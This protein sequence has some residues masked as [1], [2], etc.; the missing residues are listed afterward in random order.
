VR[1]AII[2]AAAT[3]ASM[4]A[5]T[6]TANAATV[7]HVATGEPCPAV[8]A[9]GNTISGGCLV[10]DLDGAWAMQNP[11]SPPIT[12]TSCTLNLDIRVD[13]TGTVLYG[14]N[15]T[16]NCGV[17]D[18]VACTDNTTS[19]KLPWPTTVGWSGTD[20]VYQMD[21][22]LENPTNPSY[23]TWEQVPLTPKEGPF[24]TFLGFEQNGN[25]QNGFV[26]GL[27][28]DQLDEASRVATEW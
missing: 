24:D 15:Q 26:A 3:I 2:L 5:M 16:N 14:V 10:E 18:R 1:K 6:T 11:T 21:M 27:D 9:S 20:L 23:H 8:S 12:V 7:Y 28:L 4:A 22:C 13:S 25:S 19:E 17:I